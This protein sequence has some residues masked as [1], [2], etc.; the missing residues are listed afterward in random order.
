MSRR[1]PVPSDPLGILLISG[2]HDRAHYAFVL[3]S[4]AAALGR[5]VVLFATNR[6]CLALLA[7]WSG[8]DD[9]ARDERVRRSGV[10]GLEEL[11]SA[12]QDL[13]VRFIACDA[14]LRSEQIE[15]T[16]LLPGVQVAGVAT[17][18]AEI[19]SGQIVTL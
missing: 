1:L 4:G 10:A 19:G 13:G 8:L 11:R 12:A 7:D 18:L 2:T 14:G 17:F 15:P 9:A 3:G 16:G 5:H 6:G